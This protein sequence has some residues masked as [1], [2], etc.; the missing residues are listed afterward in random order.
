MQLATATV[1]PAF[2]AASAV[3][4]GAW[5]VA[6]GVARRLDRRVRAMADGPSKTLGLVRSIRRV[7]VGLALVGIGAGTLGGISWLVTLSLIIGGEEL[8]ESTVVAAALR[9]EEGRRA[10]EAIAHAMAA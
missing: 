5:L 6:S 2:L 10:A 7:L 8:L 4:I 3:A 9:D 1:M